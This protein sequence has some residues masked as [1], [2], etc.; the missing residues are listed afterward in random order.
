MWIWVRAATEACSRVVTATCGHGTLLCLKYHASRVQTPLITEARE[1]CPGLALEC[2][3][4]DRRKVTGLSV[5]P[6]WL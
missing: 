4:R 2:S 6:G 1:A 3:A 5:E